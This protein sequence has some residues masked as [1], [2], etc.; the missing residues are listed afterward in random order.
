MIQRIQ[1][2]FLALAIVLNVAFF[3]TPLFSRAIEDPSN[4]IGTGIMG[5]IA[6]ATLLSCVVIAL[7]KNRV[8]QLQWIMRGLVFQVLAVGLCVGVLFSLGGIHVNLWDE[9][10]SVLLPFF[11][12][13]LML[14]ARSF[15]YKDEQLV[16]SMDRLR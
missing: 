11:A 3:F 10:L 12:V 14:L 13:V 9:G 15:I 2:L 4:W 1:H 5:G 6:L 8:S 16:R 7:F